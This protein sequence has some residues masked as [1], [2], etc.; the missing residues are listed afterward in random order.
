MKQIYRR[1]I[2]FYAR[3]RS[4]IEARYILRRLFERFREKKINLHIVFIDLKE[5]YYRIPNEVI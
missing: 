5:A 3:R 1:A 2:R 4:T